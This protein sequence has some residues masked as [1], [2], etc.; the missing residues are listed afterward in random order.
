ML[1]VTTHYPG[2]RVIGQDPAGNEYSFVLSDSF[3][4][5]LIDRVE[6]THV[7][8]LGT[9]FIVHF[10][11]ASLRHWRRLGIDVESPATTTDPAELTAPTL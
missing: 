9:R 10:D 5:V 7:D 6:A 11:D 1:G 2:G 4:G 3:D 8:S